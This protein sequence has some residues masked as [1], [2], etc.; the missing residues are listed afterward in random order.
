LIYIYTIITTG[1]KN[2]FCKNGSHWMAA[3]S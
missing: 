1:K 2:A 3:P